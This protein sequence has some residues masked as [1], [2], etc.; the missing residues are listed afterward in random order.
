MQTSECRSFTGCTPIGTPASSH[1]I[2]L[3]PYAQLAAL[4][5]VGRLHCTP[6]T[7]SLSSLAAVAQQPVQ[8]VR[9]NLC[10]QA[11]AARRKPNQATRDLTSL[12]IWQ[13]RRCMTRENTSLGQTP[14]RREHDTRTAFYPQT[15]HSRCAAICRPESTASERS[16]SRQS[17]I[18]DLHL[19]TW[20]PPPVLP[21]P[22]PCCKRQD[23][24]VLVP[25]ESAAYACIR[26][27]SRIS[28]PSYHR[29]YLH[30]SLGCLRPLIAG[31]RH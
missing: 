29:L 15:Y 14:A 17:I 9:R 28:A 21:P 18:H 23:L 1:A 5:I 8:T 3:Q 16:A 20:L 2:V 6:H 19:A 25:A 22:F 30:S 10:M 31:S 11:E 26:S 7:A 24:C 27:A 13:K 4:A 12:N